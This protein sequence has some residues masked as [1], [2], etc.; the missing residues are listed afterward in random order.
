[1]GEAFGVWRLAFGVRRS[2]FGVRS[3]RDSTKVAQYEVLGIMEK[4]VPV[5]LGTIEM[6]W[7]LVPKG[8]NESSPARSA[9]K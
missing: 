6:F 7:L 1:M 8:L 4:E 3:R 9:G 2:A 5:P